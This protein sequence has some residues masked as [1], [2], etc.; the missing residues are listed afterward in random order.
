MR[1]NMMPKLLFALILFSM[2]TAP[3]AAVLVLV[4]R[5]KR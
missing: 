3:A 2:L 5:T 1:V 4:M